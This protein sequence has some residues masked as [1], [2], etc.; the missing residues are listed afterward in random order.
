MT[1]LVAEGIS[2]GIIMMYALTH[3]P[4]THYADWADGTQ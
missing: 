1:N 2:K 4:H 3:A